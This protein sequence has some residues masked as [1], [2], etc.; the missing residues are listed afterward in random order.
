MRTVLGQPA[1]G[2]EG[3][4]GALV[5]KIVAMPRFLWRRWFSW[6]RERASITNRAAA[7]AAPVATKC[8]RSTTNGIPPRT[9]ASA[10]EKCHGWALTLGAVVSPEQCGA[11][12]YSHLRGD[13]PE[14]VGFPQQHRAGHQ[15]PCRAVTARSM[16]PGRPARTAPPT[17]ASFSTRSTTPRTC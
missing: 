5:K 17:R 16:P 14:Q 1:E 15:E 4:E 7:G 12:L 11:R 8:R 13:L 2:M 10:C 6:C 9:A 3:L